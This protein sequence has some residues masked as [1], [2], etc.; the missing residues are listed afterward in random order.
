MKIIDLL[1]ETAEIL[2]RLNIEYIVTGGFAVSVWGRPRSTLDI[3]IVVKLVRPK[4]NI[5]KK[6]LE[7]I[8]NSAY[9]D[10]EMMKGAIDQEGEFNFIEPE[11]GMKVDF[12]V[13]EKDKRNLL[14]L[15]R[16]RVK[17]IDNQE[18][19]FISPEDLILSKL[20]W[21]KDF[22]S[23]KH[24]EDARSVINV[25]GDQLDKE[26]LESWAKQLNVLEELN[27]IWRQ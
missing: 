7:E 25:S 18:V 1:K 11:S 10:E 23:E 12:W 19:S 6:A 5:F 3:D 9:V 17:N 14:E 26:Y 8:S 20:V 27:K 4:V 22:L 24:L 21:R 16:K 13:V 15:K 2:D